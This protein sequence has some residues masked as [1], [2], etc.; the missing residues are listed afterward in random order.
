MPIGQMSRHRRR[1]RRT[2]PGAG[3]RRHFACDADDGH[4]IAAVRRHVQFE[5]GVIE[6]QVLAQALAE[7]CILGQFNDSGIQL[8]QTELL[9]RAQHA[10][11]F[12]A[13][14]F[15]GTDFHSARQFR[16][17][18]GQGRHQAGAGVRGAADDLHV[19]AGSGGDLTDAQLIGLGVLDR[20]DDPRDD[21]T[22]ECGRRQFDGLELKARHRQSRAEL[23]RRPRYLHPLAQPGHWHSHVG[24]RQKAGNCAR[25]RKSFS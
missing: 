11:R 20:L 17:D 10:A 5:D 16:A 25:K 8:A 24:F 14:Q 7:R 21:H 4:G 9:P 15:R 23:G 3:E 19:L 1:G 6:V 13:T 12:D 22:G 2:E 18:G